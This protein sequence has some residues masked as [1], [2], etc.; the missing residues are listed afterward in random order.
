VLNWSTGQTG[1]GM[2]LCSLRIAYRIKEQV[3]RD[4]FE[5]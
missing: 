1:T 4:G 3:F 2:R 5:G